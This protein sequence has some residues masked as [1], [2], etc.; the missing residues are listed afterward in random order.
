MQVSVHSDAL[1]FHVS[2]DLFQVMCLRQL[3]LWITRYAGNGESAKL[4]KI[5]NIIPK[6]QIHMT[7]E[8]KINLES[9]SAKVNIV[10]AWYSSQFLPTDSIPSP[11]ASQ[12]YM[13]HM[14]PK[15]PIPFKICRI[16]LH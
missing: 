14:T 1:T 16:D 8:K 10:S 5:P 9:L 3:F 11:P 7:V 12:S 13:S 15:V 2:L 4:Y 6:F